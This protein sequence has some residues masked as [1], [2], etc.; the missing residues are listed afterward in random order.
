MTPG[1]RA[2]QSESKIT[3]NWLT[4]ASTKSPQPIPKN[5]DMR[6]NAPKYAAVARVMQKPMLPTTRR[7]TPRAS[8][9]DLAESFSPR[10]ATSEVN[11]RMDTGTSVKTTRVLSRSGHVE[12]TPTLHHFCPRG[13]SAFVHRSP[14]ST[15]SEEPSVPGM[16]TPEQLHLVLQ[17][18][19]LQWKASRVTGSWDT[20]TLTPAASK[21]C[22]NNSSLI[23][24]QPTRFPTLSV[25]CLQLSWS[26]RQP[27]GVCITAKGSMP[28]MLLRSS[29]PYNA[30]NIRALS[31]K[32][33]CATASNFFR[34]NAVPMPSTSSEPS[35]AR[36]A[37]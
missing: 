25:Y 7:H 13:S 37:G 1:H 26:Q 14:S 24:H 5:R 10:Q 36:G 2:P 8:T 22:S 3:S 19:G 6:Y 9:T 21:Q 17:R 34:K 32:T 35:R 31:T 18:S 11:W 27:C 12:S 33:S 23:L 16:P 4:C 28:G 15:P 30:R 20:Y 29:S